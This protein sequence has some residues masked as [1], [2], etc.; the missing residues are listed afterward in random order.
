MK[1]KNQKNNMKNKAYT[2][3]E[4]MMVIFLVFGCILGGC[5]IYVGLHF[6]AK[7]W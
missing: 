2:I 5:M 1:T 7:Y 3:I 4:L 6:L